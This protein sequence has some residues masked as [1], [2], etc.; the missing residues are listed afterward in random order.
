MYSSRYASII[1]A[2]TF[3]YFLMNFILENTAVISAAQLYDIK[4][5]LDVFEGKVLSKAVVSFIRFWCYLNIQ[6][7][8]LKYLGN[9]ITI[10]Q[11][12]LYETDVY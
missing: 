6:N 3:L 2:H 10:L 4:G 11:A 7:E 1:T 12:E 9:F 8:K 5:I